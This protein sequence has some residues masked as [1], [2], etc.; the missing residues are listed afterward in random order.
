MGLPPAEG[1]SPNSIPIHHLAH[2]FGFRLNDEAKG[3]DLDLMVETNQEV[4]QPALI[5]AQLAAKISRKMLGRKVDVVLS[6]PNLK[7][8]AIH[9]Q[10]K[11]TGAI[12]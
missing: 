2:L 5:S 12:L 6:V 11:S 8:Q 4:N 3:G 7:Q 1:H 9:S 10:A